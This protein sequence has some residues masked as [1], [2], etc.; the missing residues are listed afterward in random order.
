M[1]RG[2]FW[3]GEL[4]RPHDALPPGVPLDRTGQEQA[5][6]AGRARR[7]GYKQGRAGADGIPDLHKNGIVASKTVAYG[8]K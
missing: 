7:I 1:V 8:D 5:G 3:E 2:N 6:K 4:S